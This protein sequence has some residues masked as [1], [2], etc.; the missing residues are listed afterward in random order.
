MSLLDRLLGRRVALRCD[1]CRRTGG[2][3][4]LRTYRFRHLADAFAE[5]WSLDV[6][7]NLVLCPQ[8]S[9]DVPRAAQEERA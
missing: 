6:L 3:E 9:E 2:P 8:H 5:G 1:V 4:R 7:S